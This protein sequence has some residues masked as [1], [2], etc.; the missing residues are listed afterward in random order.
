MTGDLK[1]FLM[2]GGKYGVKSSKQDKTAA[3][4]LYYGIDSALDFFKFNADESNILLVV[5]DCGNDRKDTKV[6]SS[7]IV[8]KLVDK[9]VH[10]IGF[11][12][13]SESD[14]AFFPKLPKR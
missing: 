7:T 11:Q 1:E 13:R 9:N 8:N 4:A 12:V 6:S 5:G 3:E 14:D 10:F 2:S